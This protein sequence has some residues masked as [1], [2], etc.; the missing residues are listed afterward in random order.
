MLRSATVVLA[1]LVVLGSFNLSADA[2]ARDGTAGSRGNNFCSFGGAPRDGC[3]GYSNRASGSRGELRGYG[4]R[5][6]WGRWGP[7]T[8]L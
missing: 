1:I 6:V 3:D 8:G 5:D 4:A 7:T 2:F